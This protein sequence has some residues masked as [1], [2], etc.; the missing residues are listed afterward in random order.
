MSTY[1]MAKLMNRRFAI[2]LD[3][4]CEISRYLLPYEYDWTFC[5]YYLKTAAKRATLIE[6][7]NPVFP[8]YIQ[9]KRYSAIDSILNCS[10]NLSCQQEDA[11]FIATNEGWIERL[12]SHPNAMQTIPW[13]VNKSAPEVYRLAL[14]RL[15]RPSADITNSVRN[16]TD[17]VGTGKQ[18]ICS[19]IRTG[20]NPTM[21]HDTPK[22]RSIVPNVKFIFDWL[23][24]YDDLTKY[25]IYIA[26]DSDDVKKVAKTKLS[27]TLTIDLP[28]VHVDL[29]RSDQKNIACLGMFATLLEQHILAKCN[30]L[31]LTASN[32]GAMAAYMGGDQQ[33]VF[34]YHHKMHYIMEVN[35]SQVITY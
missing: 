34:R 10:E 24:A 32:F 9:E 26:T 19:H 1:L 8:D 29:V 11:I 12:T 5:R 18:L 25:I 14:S 2:L 33:K 16:F 20:I 4:P 21:P 3:K 6:L 7:A 28:I 31:L 13:A 23:K 30:V 27:N 35:L 15:F 17:S 22:T